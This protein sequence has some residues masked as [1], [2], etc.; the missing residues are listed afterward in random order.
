[1][2]IFPSRPGSSKPSS[3]LPHLCAERRQYLCVAAR[4]PALLT[5]EQRPWNNR[6]RFFGIA[7]LT[8]P[9]SRRARGE[10][11]ACGRSATLIDS[12]GLGFRT[13]S[14]SSLRVAPTAGAH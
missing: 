8:S 4:A 11:R 12:L 3:S 7:S 5:H 10:L 6:N 2:Q 9:G 13:R 1:M 14:A